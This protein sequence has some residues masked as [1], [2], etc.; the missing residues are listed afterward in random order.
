MNTGINQFMYGEQFANDLKIFHSKVEEILIDNNI[1][2]HIEAYYFDMTSKKLE[3][4]LELPPLI[5]EKIIEAF[6]SIF[7]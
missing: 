7:G 1:S 6:Q 4:N 3:I 2:T 5:Q